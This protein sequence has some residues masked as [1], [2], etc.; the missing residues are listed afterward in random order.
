MQCKI[1]FPILFVCFIII[2]LI[3]SK[4]LLAQEIQ[5][6]TPNQYEGKVASKKLTFNETFYVYQDKVSPFISLQPFKRRFPALVLPDSIQ[7]I[8]PDLPPSADTTLLMGFIRQKVTSP[9][10]L[11]YLDDGYI[12]F[13]L[14]LP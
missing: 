8:F 13:Q 10:H 2:S 5:V 6:M 14:H 11:K 9:G 4:S 1:V 3:P 7:L 12:H